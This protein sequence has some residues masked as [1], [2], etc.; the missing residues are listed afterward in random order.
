MPIFMTAPRRHARVASFLFIVGIFFLTPR[1][2]P[3]I[4]VQGVRVRPALQLPHDQ[5]AVYHIHGKVSAIDPTAKTLTIASKS[6]SKLMAMSQYTV[7]IKNGAA[8]SFASVAMGDEADGI[9]GMVF[10]KFT[11]I[12]VRFGPYRKDLPYGV[13][14]PDKPGYVTSPYSPRA[15]YVDVT[16]MPASIEAKDPYSGKIFLVPQ[17]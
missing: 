5:G 14:V 13:A 9:A 8:T 11:A 17:Q 6:A 10:G 15:G 2:F 16:G 3:Q 7:V 1:V 12:S 4:V